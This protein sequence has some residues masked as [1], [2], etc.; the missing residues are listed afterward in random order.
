MISSLHTLSSVGVASPPLVPVA[1]QRLVQLVLLS[2]ALSDS[3]CSRMVL[4][5]G[6]LAEPRLPKNAA[7]RSELLREWVC[8][9]YADIA[10]SSVLGPHFDAQELSGVWYL[11]NFCDES[12]ADHLGSQ[13]HF[14]SNQERGADS[15]GGS[16]PGLFLLPSP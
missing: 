3:P 2:S 16:S 9:E 12:A 14:L 5:A 1:L 6:V 11:Q 13:S 15:Q 7:P 8:P 10:Q 4:L